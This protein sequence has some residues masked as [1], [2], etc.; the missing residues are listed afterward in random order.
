MYSFSTNS[1]RAKDRLVLRTVSLNSFSKAFPNGAQRWRGVTMKKGYFI[2]LS[3][4]LVLEMRWV[5]TSSY[6]RLTWLE[7]KG[8]LL[9]ARN[10]SLA[11]LVSSRNYLGMGSTFNIWVMNEYRV[12]EYWTKKLTVGRRS[13]IDLW[14]MAKMKN[15]SFHITHRCTYMIYNELNLLVIIF[16]RLMILV[17]ILYKV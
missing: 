8:V 6:L 9:I 13:P 7:K 11:I 4:H 17:I 10:G 1:C 3:Y 16:Q 15:S 14:D 12:K 5:G 2:I